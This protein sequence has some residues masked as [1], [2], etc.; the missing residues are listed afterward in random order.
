VVLNQTFHFF[1]VILPIDVFFPLSVIVPLILRANR[2]IVD[3][4]LDGPSFDH[5]AR[6]QDV[7]V[8]GLGVWRFK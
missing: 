6:L 5:V 1:P 2:H 4:K 7:E 3:Q 8:L